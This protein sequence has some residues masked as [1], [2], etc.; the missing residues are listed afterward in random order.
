MSR[1]ISFRGLMADGTQE[2]ISLQTKTGETGYRILKI[3]CMSNNPG[4]DN[5][6]G[7]LKIYSIQQSTV[8]GT[9]DFSDNTLLAAV[10]YH[11][12]NGS[13]YPV[14]LNVISEY[15]KFNQDIYLTYNDNLV[16]VSLNYYI[17]LELM[18]LTLNESTVITLKNIRNSA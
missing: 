12:D 14:S 17:E 2:R 10:E 3:E 4:V 1:I 9:V 13:P 15:N 7:V 8:D 11:K 6:E 18:D 5:L 16:G